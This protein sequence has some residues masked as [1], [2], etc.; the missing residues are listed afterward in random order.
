VNGASS[1]AGQ[2]D[3]FRALESPFRLS[4]EKPEHALLNGS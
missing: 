2:A 4:E 1:A 3:Q